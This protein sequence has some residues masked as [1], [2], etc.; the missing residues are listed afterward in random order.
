MCL[1][2]QGVVLRLA[3][4]DK[5]Y[6]AFVGEPYASEA[7]YPEPDQPRLQIALN[8][9][10]LPEGVMRVLI[11]D[12][13]T[14]REIVQIR[15]KYDFDQWVFSISG[16]LDEAEKKTRLLICP[17]RKLDPAKESVS[18]LQGQ[19]HDLAAF[20]ASRQRVHS[21]APLRPVEDKR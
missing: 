19:G 11:F 9:W 13:K 10:S 1:E 7:P 16:V 21:P 5:V 2:D 14:F 8:F 6:G 18:T 4:G 20:F 12:T 17:E 3:V 15:D